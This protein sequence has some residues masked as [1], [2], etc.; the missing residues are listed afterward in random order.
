M[1]APARDGGHTKGPWSVFDVSWQARHKGER[2]IFVVG[3]EE[4][5]T[6]AQVRAGNSDDGLPDQ[7]PANARL[8]AASPMLLEALLAVDLACHT[9]EPADWQR[10]TDLTSAALSAATTQPEPGR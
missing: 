6:V 7:T 1:T 3:P 8:I 4:F 5:H 10:A 2:P 9:D